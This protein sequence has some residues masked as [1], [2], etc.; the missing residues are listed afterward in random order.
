MNLFEWLKANNY[1]GFKVE[2]ARLK[3]ANDIR[4]DQLNVESKSNGGSVIET[5]M[6]S[7]AICWEITPRGDDAVI[8]PSCTCPDWADRGRYTNTLCK[9]LLSAAIHSGDLTTSLKPVSADIVFPTKEGKQNIEQVEDFNERV[10]R[11][12]S[13]AVSS[14]AKDVLAVL[15]EGYV[16]FLLGPTGVG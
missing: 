8:R 9:H 2:P 4:S 5:N 1:A 6:H 11:E 14:L 12:I 13:K 16:P 10:K 15:K 7:Y 3:R